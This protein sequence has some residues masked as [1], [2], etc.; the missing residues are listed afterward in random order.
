MT[1]KEV[2]LAAIFTLYLFTGCHRQS[3]QTNQDDPQVLDSS[4]AQ[5]K[6]VT[7]SDGNQ[8]ITFALTY[9]VSSI[10]K[11]FASPEK[12]MKDVP[13]FWE[14][15]NA[16]RIL[17]SWHRYN[18]IPI[19]YE[20]WKENVEE[21]AAIAIEQRRDTPSYRLAS[22]IIG[23]REIFIQ[24][25]V[26][27]ICSFLPKKDLRIESTAYFVAFTYPRAIGV[28]DRIA[29]DLTNPYYRG[30]S[31]TIL[32][33]MVHELY[34]VGFG[35]VQFARTDPE[36][37]NPALMRMLS[38]FQNEGITTY[39]AYEAQEFFPAPY[40]EDY[41]M[42]ENKETVSKLLKALNGLIDEAGSMPADRLQKES[43]ELG[44]DRR[45]YYV[46]GAYMAQTI[47]EKAGRGAL[48]ETILKGPITF[49]TTYNSLADEN[50]QIFEL[51][52][53]P[54]LSI[55]ERLRQAAVNGEYDR[56]GELLAELKQ[57]KS[58]IDRSKEDKFLRIGLVFMQRNRNDL[59]IDIFE[60]NSKLFPESAAAY[61]YLGKAHL[62]DGNTERALDNF[63]KA[64]ALDPE[65]VDAVENLKKLS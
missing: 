64:V 5:S 53:P 37:E 56:Y 47:D 14:N 41:S 58:D 15:E 61:N 23:A 4:N 48:N 30:S 21:I 50:M 52:A 19:D 20:G 39:M 9:D 57:R 1:T 6:P 46:V 12:V 3:E 25:A 29:I 31:S 44:V 27:H 17:K 40:E 62:Q 49:I 24:Q 35:R 2:F 45:A 38:D 32:N 55:F 54:N 65:Y 10:E 59:A 51:D 13:A 60:F 36:F 28:G 34:H 11:I 42:L 7:I 33:S 43:W 26:P 8:R 18:N 63:T 16:Y 22:D